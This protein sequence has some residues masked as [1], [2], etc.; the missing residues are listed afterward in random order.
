MKR[1]SDS[2]SQRPKKKPSH[3]PI[4]ITVGAVNPPASHLNNEKR[5]F[6]TSS[7][8]NYT[9]YYT[10][11]HPQGDA[12][13]DYRIDLLDASI[14]NGKSVLD[15]G[16]NSGNITIALAQKYKP[17]FIKGIDIDENLIRKA[18]TNLR[19]AYSLRD[20]NMKE[21][22]HIDLAL[23]SHYFPKCL[24]NMYGLLQMAV[25]P[26][27]ERTEFPWTVEFET[28]DWTE[29]PYNPNE[30]QYDTILALSLTK[31]IQLHGGDKGIKSFFKKVFDS[32]SRDG[33]FVVEPQEL[34]YTRAKNLNLD[35]DNFKFLPEHYN[36]FLMNKLGFKK[37]LDLG[38]PKGSSTSI[39]MYTK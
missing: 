23:Q 12:T 22:K 38:A 17:S 20:P 9:S 39:F 5:K 2:S 18:N 36:D 25:P 14:F 31:W 26:T 34:K 13:I 21:L 16:C 8:G 32:L 33:S 10:T 3:R 11:R 30:Q 6:G 15:L 4:H 7:Y 28:V 19:I 29:N 35:V 24:S 37:C 1:T 27:F